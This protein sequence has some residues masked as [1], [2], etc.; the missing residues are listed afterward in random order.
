MKLSRGT[1]YLPTVNFKNLATAM[2]LQ[3]TRVMCYTRASF[4]FNLLI[5]FCSVMWDS[6]NSNHHPIACRHVPENFPR[7]AELLSFFP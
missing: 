6:H 5:L 4:F 1:M 2:Q 7:K 3:R